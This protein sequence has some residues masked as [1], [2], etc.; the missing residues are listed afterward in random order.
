MSLTEPSFLFIFL[1][2]FLALFALAG[3][4][5]SGRGALAVL[6]FASLV[7]SAT[8]GP[9]FLLLMTLSAL[10]NY[11][12]LLGI[13]LMRGRGSRSGIFLAVGIAL[14]IALLVLFKYSAWLQW[15]PA[16]GPISLGLSAY[17]PITLSF[18]T[19][20]R[21]VALLD[22][23]SQ[24]GLVTPGLFGAQAGQS[25]RPRLDGSLRFLSF[26]TM[27][28]NLL[29]GPIAYLTEVLPQFRESAFGKVKSLNLKIGLTLLV[30]G[31]FK[32]VV[33]A[34]EL[35]LFAVDPVYADLMA[36]KIVAPLAALL[37][38]FGYFAQLYFDFSGYSD[39]VLGIARM[40]GIRLPFNFESPLRAVGIIDFYRR[41]HITLTRVIA[42]FLFTPLSIMGTRFAMRRKQKGVPARLISLW[43]PLLINFIVIGLWHGPALTFILFGTAHGIWYVIETE[44]R[45][46]KRWKRF[47]MNS[48]NLLR[49]MIGAAVTVP[50]L[51]VSFALFRSPSLAVFGDLLASLNGD[52]TRSGFD[53]GP[54]LGILRRLGFA[55]AILYL[56]PNAYELL[57]RYRPGIRSFAVPSNTLPILRLIWR[58][59]L[60]WG[61]FIA[62]LGLAVLEFLSR[63][64]PFVYRL[65]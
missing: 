7:I 59:T 64:A 33:I 40:F 51:I 14:N 35:G 12:L 2:L 52:W 37:A 41:W 61:L 15:I 60:I 25:S 20:Q 36:G 49:S 5:G 23:Y 30:I 39:M 65:Y 53:K 17:I 54:L 4:I 24:P 26:A 18:L 19:F 47:R 55:Y 32:K 8:Q 62:I 31:L 63:S 57:A 6:L 46:T 27:F 21:A 28:P 9:W 16:I 43:I 56:A 42:R 48:S 22:G 45:A 38:L 44:V 29:I 1:P 13:M 34:D 3:K 58:P 50:L 10:I 11:A